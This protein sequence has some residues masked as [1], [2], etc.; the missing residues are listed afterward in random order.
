MRANIFESRKDCWTHILFLIISIVG[1]VFLFFFIYERNYKSVVIKY[2]KN[3]IKPLIDNSEYKIIRLENNLD[4]LLISD[5]TASKSAGAMSINTGSFTDEEDS[6]G[7]AHLTEHLIFLGSEKYQQPGLFE[8]HLEKHYGYSNAY[9]APDLTTYYFEINSEGFSHAADIFSNMF[10][11]PLFSLEYMD[12]EINAVNSENNK[13]FNN[14]LWRQHQLIKSL[15]NKESVFNTF[16]T[17]NNI[18]LKE[19]DSSLLNK[20]VKSYF[21]KYYVP[22]NMKLTLISNLEIVALEDL[23]LKYFSEIRKDVAHQEVSEFKDNLNLKAFNS[24]LLGKLVWWNKKSVGQNLD[25]LFYMDP[26][27]SVYKSKPIQYLS[28]ILGYTGEKSLLSVLMEKKFATKVE[29]GVFESNVGFTLFSVSI[30]LTKAGIENITDVLLLVWDYIK[31]VRENEVKEEIFEELKFSQQTNFNFLDKPSKYSDYSANLAGGMHYVDY[32]DVLFADYN[33]DEY[34]QALIEKFKV[35][36]LPENCLIMIGTQSETPPTKFFEGLEAKTEYWYKT[37]YRER[38]LKDEELV[39]F[40]NKDSRIREDY[41]L[42]PKNIFV[43]KESKQVQCTNENALVCTKEK[44]EIEASLFVN[45]PT[46]NIWYRQ[47]RSFNVPK[48]ITTI[49]LLVPILKNTPQDILILKYFFLHLSQSAILKLSSAE[50]AGN[51]ISVD[52]SQK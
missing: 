29:S 16:A 48:V 36:L 11:S 7:L 44:E 42:R 21:K 3:I 1:L 38:K 49:K 24:S 8:K 20:R 27:I 25:F 50:E 33:Y 40:L 52:V 41:I 26:V 34:D 22:Q 23:C 32:R 37:Q 17:G 4:V 13:N 31:L 19:L 39:R 28:Y 45:Y 46:L 51:E 10:N 2:N 5:P 47:D 14:D 43:S 9:T 12:K 6:Q 30:H 35:K 15:S 18:S